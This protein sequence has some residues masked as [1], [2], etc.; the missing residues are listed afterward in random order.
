MMNRQE[1]GKKKK[2]GNHNNQS[3]SAT[4]P[5]RATRNVP[6]PQQQPTSAAP[7]RAQCRPIHS[8]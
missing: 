4:N 7:S 8:Y 2:K 5:T 6:L 3:G 1:L